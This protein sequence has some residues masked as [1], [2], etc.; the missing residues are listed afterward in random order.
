MEER[1]TAPTY[2]MWIGNEHY[3]SAEEWIQEA[4][5]L[6]VSKRLPNE[7]VAKKLMEPGAVVFVA[8]DDGQTK[9]CPKCSAEIDCPACRVALQSER[10]ELDLANHLKTEGEKHPEDSKARR[11]HALRE[12]N[13]RLRADAFEKEVSECEACDGKLRL[14]TS[15]G[16]HVVFGDGTKWDY[17]QYNYWLH[18]PKKWSPEELGGVEKQHMCAHCGGTGQ[19]PMGKVVGLFVPDR[20]QIIEDGDKERMDKLVKD[21]FEL[22]STDLLRVEKKRKCG[23]RK[24][25]GVYAITLGG[26]DGT[27]AKKAAKAIGFGTKEVEVHGNFARFI[28]PVEIP[29]EKRFR[30]IK[31]F[32]LKGN[33]KDKIRK[34]ADLIAEASM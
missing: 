12:R 18:Q 19:L 8:H 7:H 20:L 23:V 15:S 6:G 24:A 30:G 2:L 21:G 34:E 27:A 11:S 26:D 3:A 33:S 22:V 14:I 29:D 1:K 10:R 9:D 17:R 4:R 25:G 32:S 28:S 16:G 5:E 13:A 31:H